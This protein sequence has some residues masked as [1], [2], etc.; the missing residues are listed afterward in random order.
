MPIYTSILSKE[1]YGAQAVIISF[2][3]F[4]D[5]ISNLNIHSGVGRDYYETN[6]KER[7]K[8]ISTGLYSIICNSLL[9][10][11]VLLICSRWI[12]FD[13]LE[14]PKYHKEFCV[15]TL[16][17]ITTSCQTFFSVLTRFKKKPILFTIGTA[18]KI[19]IQISIS[20]FGVVYLKAGIMSFIVG[21]LCAGIFGTIY[22]GLLNREN[23]DVV[24]DRLILRRV[25]LFSLPTIPAIVA[26]WL[27]GSLGQILIGKYISLEHAGV[28]SIALHLCSGFA[29]LTT[30]FQNVW[31]PFLFE[32]YK[33]NTFVA[34]VN[35]LYM[36]IMFFLILISI[37]ISLLSKEIV[38]LLTNQTYVEAAKYLTLLC[39]PMSI[40]VTFPFASSGVNISRDTKYIGF[41]YVLGS[42]INVVIMYL[43]LS[44]IG[45]ICVPLALA[46]S[47]I[48]TYYI[49]YYTTKAKKLLVLPQK[50]VFFLIISVLLCYIISLWA[51]TM[52]RV[53][54]LCLINAILA[55]IACKMMN[56]KNIL[57]K[58]QINR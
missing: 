16:T 7:D 39:I 32:N 56:L 41:A 45:V 49:L 17:L 14:I 4:F 48:T 50:H 36:I 3:L 28:Y 11:I 29:L 27:D 47:R 2:I 53:L 5:V 8:L 37:N 30:A 1:E 46:A 9:V 42:I 26:G 40:Y 34:D 19:L 54:I 22:Y 15:M 33:K 12:T 31:S 18:I 13:I 20:L 55:V 51:N 44:R 25:L 52:I 23:I 10:T 57:T 6:D 21:S 43:L 58:L 35:K 24:F 38:I